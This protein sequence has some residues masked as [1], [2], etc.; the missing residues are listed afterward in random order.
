MWFWWQRRFIL[1]ACEIKRVIRH[2]DIRWYCQCDV[3]SSL[4]LTVDVRCVF[5]WLLCTNTYTK[6]IIYQWTGCMAETTTAKAYVRLIVREFMHW[7]RC[8]CH[9]LE[10]V[11]LAYELHY[12]TVFNASAFAD[13]ITCSAAHVMRYKRVYST[14]TFIMH[15]LPLHICWSQSTDS[16]SNWFG[17][18]GCVSPRIRLSWMFHLK[19]LIGN[20]LGEIFR[21]GWIKFNQWIKERMKG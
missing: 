9:C 2:R 10:T 3:S 14:F 15:S 13:A 5:V 20:W 8:C 7:F 19:F 4:A 21:E 16:P 1:I 11:C 12:L 18:Y 17:K 6:E